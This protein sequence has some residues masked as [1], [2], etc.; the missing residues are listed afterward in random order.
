MSI[1]LLDELWVKRSFF[2]SSRHLTTAASATAPVGGLHRPRGRLLALRGFSL[3]EEE[4]KA[5]RDF[6]YYLR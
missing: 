3:L 6:K 4:A 2:S 5:K 1:Y